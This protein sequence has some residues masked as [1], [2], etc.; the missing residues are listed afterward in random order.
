MLNN[1]KNISLIS[2]KEVI[3]HKF[4][5]GLL[6]AALFIISV[7]VILGPLSM[8]EE[9]RI[10]VDFGLFGVQIVI[11]AIS[12][13]FGSLSITRDLEKKALMTLLSKPVSRSD[14]VLGK[15][16]G[17]S[18][19]SF[20]SVIVLGCF[21][22][23]LF[24]YVGV[25]LHWIHLQALWGIYLES[26]VILSFSILFSTF[27]FSFLN[28]IFSSSLFIIGHWIETVRQIVKTDDTHLWAQVMDYIWNI[29][30]NLEKFNWRS[31]AVYG[32]FVSME[33]VMFYSFYAIPWVVLSM[34]IAV[35]LFKKKDI[36]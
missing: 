28:I 14:Y 23:V 3:R 36:I 1:I 4:F 5:Y 16:L 12:I 32:D 26:L 25:P 33:E 31:H 6:I 15:F 13:F 20:M 21:V 19:V 17:I 10:A 35:N 29:L 18:I 11:I 2:L 30:P 22:C 34:V 27:T 9:K 24:L 8:T 7:S